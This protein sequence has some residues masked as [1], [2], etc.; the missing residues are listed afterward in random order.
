MSREEL[1]HEVRSV[2]IELSPCLR[3]AEN[4]ERIIRIEESIV[5]TVM[6]AVDRWDN[7]AVRSQQ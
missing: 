3:K 4:R 5:A 6:S 1:E 2:V 7:G